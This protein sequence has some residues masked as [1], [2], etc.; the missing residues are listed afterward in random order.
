MD[1][2]GLVQL[3]KSIVRP[4]L[5]YCSP[6]WHPYLKKDITKVEKV[7]RRATKLLQPLKELQY[8][9][10]L[11][12]LNL[13][14]LFYRR[15]RSDLIQM[16]KIVHGIDELQPNKFFQFSSVSM[17]RGHKF[18]VFKRQ[19]KTKLRQCSF[20]QRV[21]SEWN[22][23]PSYV[24]ESSSI[25]VFKSN[26]ERYWSARRNKFDPCTVFQCPCSSQSAQ[27]LPQMT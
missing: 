14:S 1:E 10:R 19:V 24:A 2:K 25:N 8:E 11:K 4:S 3:Y 7:Q 22:K 17:T 6:V 13:P 18:K 5:E 21:I 27:R 16:Y 26:L 20:S 23:L 15:H 12:R 9:E